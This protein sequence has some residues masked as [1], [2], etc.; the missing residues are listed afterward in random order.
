[1]IQE[2]KNIDPALITTS[3]FFTRSCQHRHHGLHNRCSPLRER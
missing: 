3:P 1:M 2:K